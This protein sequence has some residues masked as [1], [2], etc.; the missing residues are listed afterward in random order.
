MRVVGPSRLI[1]ILS[2]IPG[3]SAW[4]F[5]GLTVLS[6]FTSAFGVVAGL[7]GGVLLIGVMANLFPPAVLIPLHG[8]VQLGTNVS[9]GIIMRRQVGWHLFPAFAVGAV[10]G[11]V[12]GGQ[13]VVSLPTAILQ[14]VLGL[15]LIYVCWAPKPSP[16]HAYSAPK[17]FALGTVGSLISMF[18]GA[19]G[20]ILAPFIAAAC[21]DR[22][23]FVATSSVMMTVVHGL[24]VVVF[25]MLGFAFVTYLPLMA[26]MIGAAFLGSMF[27][28]SVLNRMPEKVF[29]RVFQIVLTI[30]SLRL[31]YA[32]LSAEGW[33]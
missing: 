32:G 29:Q 4:T 3:V 5:A 17:F 28:R 14:I 11:A 22:H 9:R 10:A 33:I 26:T 31:L 7:G 6:F 21:R 24:K 19:T 8:T 13:L 25:G 18:V 30:L 1:D 20:T 23:E 12:V 27:G 15:F 2:S 16:A